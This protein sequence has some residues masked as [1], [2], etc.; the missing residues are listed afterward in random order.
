MPDIELQVEIG[1]P[2]RRI[3]TALTTSYG[4]RAWWWA[5]WDD[6]LIAVDARVGG[7]YRMSADAAGLVVA[8]VY[9]EVDRD[10]G[11]LAFTWERSDHEGTSAGEACEIVVTPAGVGSRLTLRHTWPAGDVDPG[12]LYRSRWTDLLAQLTAAVV[13]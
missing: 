8:G 12:E 5:Q 3:W 9:T 6:V 11:R 13:R 1:A 10:A 4:L 7:A 2:P